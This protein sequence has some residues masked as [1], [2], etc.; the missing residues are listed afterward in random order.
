MA[1]VPINRPP[2][3]AMSLDVELAHAQKALSEARKAIRHWTVQ[4]QRERDRVAYVR[5]LKKRELRLM[6][7]VAK[8]LGEAP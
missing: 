4:A 7:R 3:T 2:G 8:Q 5:L 6:E 1:I